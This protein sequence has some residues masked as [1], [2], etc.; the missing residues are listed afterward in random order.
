MRNGIT[1]RLP[2]VAG[3]LG[4]ISGYENTASQERA[5]DQ[6]SGSAV[7]ESAFFVGGVRSKR[8]THFHDREHSGFVG[9]A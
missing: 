8:D 6:Q 5:A 9:E 2:L 4:G 1:F 3:R 7:V